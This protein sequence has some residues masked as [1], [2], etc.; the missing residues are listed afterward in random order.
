MGRDVAT[1]SSTKTAT[2]RTLVL[3]GSGGDLAHWG[4]GVLERTSGCKVLSV[5]DTA[6]DLLVLELLLDAALLALLLIVLLAGLPVCARSEH[7]I[8]CDGSSI[9]RGAGSVALLKTELG[10]FSPLGD[11]GVDVLLHDGLLDPPCCLD[12]LAVIVDSVSD[13]SLCA[14]FVVDDLLSWELVILVVLRPIAIKTA[15][16]C[17]VSHKFS[18]HD[19]EKR[20][21]TGN[22]YLAGLDMMKDICFQRI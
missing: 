17:L 14:I 19:A 13:H 8:L 11:V 3:G 12:F 10:P 4:H 20:K 2:S 9:E 21:G 6:L 7:D 5:T 18:K 15:Q 22:S 16:K 1:T